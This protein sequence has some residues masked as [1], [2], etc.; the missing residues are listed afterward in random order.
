MRKIYV[1]ISII[2][3]AITVFVG[4]TNSD[5]SR[6]RE[7]EIP[8]IHMP[9]K[10]LSRTS[11]YDDTI[12]FC[13]QSVNRFALNEKRTDI[14][15]SRGDGSATTV[16][17]YPYPTRPTPLPVSLGCFGQGMAYLSGQSTLTW[18]PGHDQ[19]TM[20]AGYST[21]DKFYFV[22]VN[23]NAEVAVPGQVVDKLNQ[24]L[25]GHYY[26]FTWS[27][28]GELF[29]TR[30]LGVDSPGLDDI[31][32]YNPE[33]EQIRK[34]TD[35]HQSQKPVNLISW[36]TTRNR[37]AVSYTS[38]LA[39]IGIIDLDTLS[40][41]D[42]NSKNSSLLHDWTHSIDA[43]APFQSELDHSSAPVWIDNDQ[44]IIFSA[45]ASDDRVTL[46]VVNSDGTE[47][48]EL[49]PG[50]PGLITQAALSPDKKS[51]AFVRFPNWTDRPDRAEIAAVDLDTKTI[52]SLA[53]L[54]APSDGRLLFVSG[55]DWT[56]DGNYLAFSSN[57]GRQSDI[58]VMSADGEAWFNLTDKMDG[59]AKSPVWRP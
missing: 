42:V 39:G 2:V 14:I 59:D 38:S 43:L 17:T 24:L 56:S 27:P 9:S 44:R 47:L 28:T 49:L 25:Y 46:F 26:A 50:L 40:Y 22:D 36:A 45:P 51:L 35:L 3:A 16:I 54:P 13:W 8:D 11:T 58:Y 18:R 37:L 48:Q 29:A 1:Y 4:C 15:V 31:W 5:G 7:V 33:S 57:H 10:I 20:A 53:V 21:P 32:L 41:V 34:V 30:G 55:I 19:I 6:F 12:A 52:Y 23:N